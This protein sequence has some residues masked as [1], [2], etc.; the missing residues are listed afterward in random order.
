MK[1]LIVVVGFL[2]CFAL[3]ITLTVLLIHQNESDKLDRQ[4]ADGQV[5]SNLEKFAGSLIPVERID[6]Y[7]AARIEKYKIETAR[8]IYAA[9][10]FC[11]LSSYRRYENFC[12]L[13]S[14]LSYLSQIDK[15]PLAICEQDIKD[16]LYLCAHMHDRELVESLSAELMERIKPFE[17]SLNA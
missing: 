6:E 17:Y 1:K 11:S 2:L 16:L 10:G 14:G 7:D 5:V 13:I 3:I 15:L 12:S 4:S 8:Y 9:S